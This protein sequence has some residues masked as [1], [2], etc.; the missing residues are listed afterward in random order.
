MNNADVCSVAGVGPCVID[1][2][3]LGICPGHAMRNRSDAKS[4][5]GLPVPAFGVDT[6][7]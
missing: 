3:E 2:G 1:N 4:G 7:C 5:S 6:I